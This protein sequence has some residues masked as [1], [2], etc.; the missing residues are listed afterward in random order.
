MPLLGQKATNCLPTSFKGRCN[1]VIP[2]VGRGKLSERQQE[3]DNVHGW[4]R[5]RV[6]HC[7]AHLWH[8]CILRDI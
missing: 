4:Y 2:F 7:F 1:S 3:Y 5:A 6:E 8:W